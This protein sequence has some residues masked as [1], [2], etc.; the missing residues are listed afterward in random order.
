[1]KVVSHEEFDQRTDSFAS[2]FKFAGIFR[3]GVV[4]FKTAKNN[5]GKIKD[6]AECYPKPQGYFKS[7]K[8]KMTVPDPKIYGMTMKETVYGWE[9]I[10]WY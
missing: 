3:D 2:E 5:F 10:N 8:R 7:W 6:H 1:M 4:L 9:Q